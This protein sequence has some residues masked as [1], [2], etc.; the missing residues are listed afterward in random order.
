MVNKSH[1][2]VKEQSLKGKATAPQNGLSKLGHNSSTVK[3]LVTEYETLEQR[4]KEIG[5]AQREIK[6]KLKEQNIPTMPLNQ[7]LRERKMEDDV[8]FN[9]LQDCHIIR[10]T[11]GMQATLFDKAQ[12]EEGNRGMNEAEIEASQKLKA[13][14]TGKPDPVAAAKAMAK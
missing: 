9:F 4:K 5:K 12:F 8:R 14:S 13:V 1:E 10:D 11:L 2:L 7:I 6:A 3:A